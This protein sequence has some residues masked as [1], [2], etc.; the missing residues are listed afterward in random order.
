[1]LSNVYFTCTQHNIYIY[2]IVEG[3][4]NP[5]V[6]LTKM[7]QIYFTTENRACTWKLWQSNTEHRIIYP[8]RIELSLSLYAKKPCMP[9][10]SG[11]I[12]WCNL[13]NGQAKNPVKQKIN[14]NKSIRIRYVK[15]GS[16][17]VIKVIYDTRSELVC[18]NNQLSD[19]N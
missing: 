13:G 4:T 3:S 9:N 11:D 18:T 7:K 6:F 2:S 17:R 8:E 16:R 15:K 12:I 5:F 10:G 19:Y 1:M 14:F